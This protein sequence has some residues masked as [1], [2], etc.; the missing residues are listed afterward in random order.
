MRNREYTEHLTVDQ[1]SCPAVV[2]HGLHFG[3]HLL[4]RDV[5][6]RALL[7]FSDPVSN[8]FVPC[9][10]HSVGR[11]VK[12]TLQ[13]V[14]QPGHQRTALALWQGKDLGLKVFEY[15]IHNFPFNKD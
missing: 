5:L 9:A 4:V 14:Q 11:I 3:L 8:F 7:K 1:S 10:C 12:H 2:K 6:S 13:A 15:G